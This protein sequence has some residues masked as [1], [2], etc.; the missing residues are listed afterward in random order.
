MDMRWYAAC[1][2]SRQKSQGYVFSCLS[3][4]SLLRFLPKVRPTT[5]TAQARAL[6]AA[7]LKKRC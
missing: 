3:L 5:E 4:F 2:R 6:P 7:P 1:I